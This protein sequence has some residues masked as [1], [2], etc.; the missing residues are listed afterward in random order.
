MSKK[1]NKFV[2]RRC[3]ANHGKDLPS[4][5]LGAPKTFLYCKIVDCSLRALS[6]PASTASLNLSGIVRP[7]LV[8]AL[9][10]RS[11]APTSSSPYENIEENQGTDRRD[12]ENVFKRTF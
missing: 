7:K 5:G 1:K 8:T 11:P 12:N 9:E 4:E 3:V 2:S 6:S 10:K